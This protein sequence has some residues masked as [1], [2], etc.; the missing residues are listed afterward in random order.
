MTTVLAPGRSVRRLASN[1]L[2]GRILASIAVADRSLFV[3][4][5]THLYRITEHAA[6]RPAGGRHK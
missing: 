2:D 6:G 1:A 3:R 5:D 4:T